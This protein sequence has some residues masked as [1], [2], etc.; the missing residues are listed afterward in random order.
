MYPV[1]ISFKLFEY[2]LA[3][4]PRPTLEFAA[5]EGNM[6]DTQSKLCSCEEVQIRRN[7]CVVT[8]FA[9][10]FCV[11]A[12]SE[13]TIIN[14][15]LDYGLFAAADDRDGLSKE[16]QVQLL[17]HVKLHCEC[18]SDIA[19]C[20]ILP[21]TSK[22]RRLSHD[23]IP[24]LFGSIFE[25]KVKTESEAENLHHCFRQPSSTLR[26]EMDH[27]YPGGCHRAVEKGIFDLI[28]TNAAGTPSGR[29]YIG[30]RPSFPGFLK[31]GYTSSEYASRRVLD[32]K[33]KCFKDGLNLLKETAEVPWPHRLEQIIFKELA[34]YR[35]HQDCGICGKEHTEW[36]EVKLSKAESVIKRWA[37]WCLRQPYS[38]NKVLSADW[39]KRVESRLNKIQAA[40]KS[41]GLFTLIVPELAEQNLVESLDEFTEA[42][43]DYRKTP[44]VME[45]CMQTRTAGSL[46]C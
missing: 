4:L 20:A 3:P 40:A 1:R 25:K 34:L 37:N 19:K 2:D 12:Y 44:P 38:A 45:W 18:D 17:N 21:S 32:Q 9:L 8:N 7:K 16:R 39:T 31:I 15:F 24:S 27:N 30:Q 28:K 10:D 26:L 5:T 13:E 29:I 11:V 36:F 43:I 22:K 35:R 46:R 42:G 33:G 23:G 14:V 6:G 41:R